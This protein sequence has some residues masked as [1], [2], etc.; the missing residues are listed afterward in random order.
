MTKR[1]GYK[2]AIN[3]KNVIVSLAIVLIFGVGL[4]MTDFW[5]MGENSP[6]AKEY[7]AQLRQDTRVFID[8]LIAQIDRLDGTTLG[9]DRDNILDAAS[10]DSEEALAEYRIRQQKRQELETLYLKVLTEQR[11]EAL[12]QIN[13]LIEQG[14]A[15]WNLL[16]VNGDL[17]A[18]NKEALLAEYLAKANVLEDQMDE[19]FAVLLN[20]IALQLKSEG[21]DPDET[22]GLYQRQYTQTK[23]EN[24]TALM[25]K[26]KNAMSQ[27]Q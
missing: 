12:R 7:Q 16:S 26:V 21:F 1:N 23:D 27:E 11:D 25:T 2:K 15:D 6:K 24:R 20:R 13:Q 9:I 8:S 17:T 22:I 10:P 19:S 5:R 18:E 14:Q 4:I 3:V